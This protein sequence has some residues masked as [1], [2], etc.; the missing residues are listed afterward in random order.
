MFL[1]IVPLFSRT[2][3]PRELLVGGVPAGN[4]FHCC[5]QFS[6]HT[7]EGERRWRRRGGQEE[8]EEVEKEVEEDEERVTGGRGQEEIEEEELEE[9]R[10]TGTEGQ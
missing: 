1:L 6:L 7:G 3:Q 8:E 5:S 4:W 9:E 10:R 2:P